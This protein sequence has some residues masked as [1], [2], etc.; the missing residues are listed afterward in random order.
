MKREYLLTVGNRDCQYFDKLMDAIKE[1]LR[2]TSKGVNP[3]RISIYKPVGDNRYE[4][5][6]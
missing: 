1:R 5:V 3:N 4:L 2:L 6:S